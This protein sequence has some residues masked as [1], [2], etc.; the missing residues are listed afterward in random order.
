PPSR[1]I[2]SLPTDADTSQALPQHFREPPTPVNTAL[3]ERSAPL[4]S[5]KSPSQE[6]STSPQATTLSS[7]TQEDQDTL[8]SSTTDPSASY[9]PGRGGPKVIVDQDSPLTVKKAVQKNNK[10]TVLDTLS[11]L[12][13]VQS[14]GLIQDKEEGGNV[15]PLDTT[16]SKRSMGFFSRSKPKKTPSG[17]RVYGDSDDEAEKQANEVP[18]PVEESQQPN[19]VAA[20]T[21]NITLMATQGSKGRSTLQRKNSIEIINVWSIIATD[22]DNDPVGNRKKAIDNI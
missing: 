4:P 22:W 18:N 5:T 8:T 2:T 15:A 17:P 12:E 16:A 10:Q 7:P 1:P 3:P 14:L 13:T 20:P 11:S 9:I 21:S 19:G 6:S